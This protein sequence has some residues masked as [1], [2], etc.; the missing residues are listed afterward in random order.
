MCLMTDRRCRSP[1]WRDTC[2]SCQLSPLT[3]ASSIELSSSGASAAYVTVTSNTS[4]AR[5]S[6]GFSRCNTG[7]NLLDHPV[8]GAAALLRPIGRYPFLKVGS[9]DQ[10][11]AFHAVTGERMVWIS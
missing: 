3:L 11:F 5:G 9:F 8:K 7:N 1:H 4:C 10:E 2:N 6:S